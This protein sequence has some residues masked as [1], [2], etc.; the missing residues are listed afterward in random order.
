MA[1][2]DPQ[3]TL[4]ALY[5]A[6]DNILAGK[7][8]SYQLGDRNIQLLDLDTVEKLITKYENILASAGPVVADLTG[9]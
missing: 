7:V 2:Q 5:A 4:D 3:T 1:L 9:I 6:R 8:A